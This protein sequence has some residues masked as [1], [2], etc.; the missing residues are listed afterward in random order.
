MY[1]NRAFL[2]CRISGIGAEYGGTIKISTS[3]KK[4]KSWDKRHKL[5]TE[6]VRC[7]D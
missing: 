1:K 3:G 2:E 4:C 7:R 6:E 5:A